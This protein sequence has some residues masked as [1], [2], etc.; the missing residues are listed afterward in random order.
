MR[1]IILFVVLTVLAPVLWAAPG[2]YKVEYWVANARGGVT[3]PV[4]DFASYVN[5]S[6]N[7]GISVRKGLDMDISVGGGINYCMLNYKV[8]DA[9][10]PFSAMILDAEIAYTPYLPDFFIWPYMKAGLALYLVKYSKLADADN[11][12]TA[13]ETTFGFMMGGGAIY[14]ISNIFGL[15]LEVMYNHVSLAGG[16]GDLNTFLSLNAGV[17]MWLK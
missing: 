16:T 4:G 10:S 17:V 8:S 9:P 5:P 7:G 14:P 2:A 11:A 6:L 12:I 1:K 3:Y 13:S 15:N